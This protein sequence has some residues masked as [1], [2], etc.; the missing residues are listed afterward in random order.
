M[1]AFETLLLGIVTG[2]GTVRL[3]VAPP[4]ATVEVRLDSATV[5][6]LTSA[7][8]QMDCD[9][10]PN[11]MP[12][13]LTAIGR[14]PVGHEVSR[15]TQ[16][17]NVG[18]DRARISAIIERDPATRQPIALRLAWDTI[19]MVQPQAVIAMLDGTPLAVADVH[20]IP[21]PKVG[22][23]W[24]HLVSVEAFFPPQLRERADLAFGGDVVERAES[25]LT[26][27]AVTLPPGVKRLDLRDVRGLFS[28]GGQPLTPIAVDEGHAEVAVVVDRSVPAELDVHRSKWA[29]P[30][31]ASTTRFDRLVHAPLDPETSRFIFVET[32]PSQRLEQGRKHTYFRSSEPTRLALLESY[33][34]L[35]WL[36]WLTAASQTQVQT[37]ADA[38]AVAGSEVAASNHRRAVILLVATRPTPRGTAPVATDASTY[39]AAAVRAYLGALDVP[40]VVWSLTGA[41]PEQ[42]TAAWG[43]AVAIR[44]WWGIREQ[45]KRLQKAL[46]AQRIVWFA[47]RYLPQRITLDESRTEIRLAR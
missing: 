24:P 39:D 27:V 23:T 13:E 41:A 31:R 14:D 33:P 8:W 22:L 29:P 46:D 21:L 10:G 16:W 6:V 19:E 28:I 1:V 18:H 12:H 25:E 44:D 7:P 5:A 2:L 42:L 47:G 40:L 3:M 17:V 34:L 36:S 26:A 35:F 37:I 15:A 45:V 32:A 38:V 43:P 4:V 30:V 11:P 9:F 20:R